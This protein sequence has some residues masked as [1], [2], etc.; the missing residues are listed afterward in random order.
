MSL[1]VC[2]RV[3]ERLCSLTG[4]MGLP[5]RIGRTFSHFLHLI[6][7]LKFAFFWFFYSFCNFSFVYF[8][9]LLLF[10]VVFPFRLHLS[11]QN[12]RLDCSLRSLAVLCATTSFQFESIGRATPISFA[13]TAGTSL[14]A[15]LP[16]HVSTP[17][18]MVVSV[19]VYV[20]VRALGISLSY[21]IACHPLCCRY[22]VTRQLPHQL[23][24]LTY[25][26]PPST[27]AQV[28]RVVSFPIEWW[29]I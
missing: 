10:F 15:R 17:I 5:T 20:C 27:C 4:V 18:G 3:R 9:F 28:P 2:V 8:I 21:G 23:P 22:R 6:N 29:I 25:Y 26:Q 24:T 14:L 19:C 12:S 11:P 13:S 7:S 1:C 16:L